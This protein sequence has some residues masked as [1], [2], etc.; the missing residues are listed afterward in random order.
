MR[1]SEYLYR[2][3]SDATTGSVRDRSKGESLPVSMSMITMGLTSTW[4]EDI[5]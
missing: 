4:P 5:A 2:P 3:L 1:C